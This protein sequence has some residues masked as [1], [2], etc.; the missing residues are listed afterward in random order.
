MKPTKD[1]LLMLVYIF[2]LA[3]CLGKFPAGVMPHSNTQHGSE[4]VRSHPQVLSEIT[5]SLT[6]DKKTVKRTYADLKSSTND[7]M[8]Q[9]DRKQVLYI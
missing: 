1:V 2:F 5:N 8:R 3:E 4:Y 6:L 9:R 7:V